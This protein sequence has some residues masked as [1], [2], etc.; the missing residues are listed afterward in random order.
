[1]TSASE[2]VWG[3]NLTEQQ[4]LIQQVELYVPEASW[5]L[6]HLQIRRGSRVV[7]LGCGPLGILDL[8]AERVG[9]EGEV[10]GVELESRFVEMAKGLMTERKLD[11]V[12]VIQGDAAATGL[13]SDF[14][15]L[16]HGRLLLI[17]VPEP[18]RVVAE[19]V[20]LVRPGG[21]I[22]VEEVDVY[23]WICEPSHPAWTRLFN[24]FETLYREDSKDPRVGRRVPRMLRAAGLDK[25]DCNVHARV[26]G[27]GDFHQEQLLLFVKLF[28]QRIIERGLLQEEELQTT[29]EDLRRHL[30]DPGTLVVSPLL[31]Q[32]WGY[33]AH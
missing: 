29:F 8:L 26:N 25:V 32:A 2:Y 24:A 6:D 11:V 20:R 27:P 5:L 9:P 3:T 1:M 23:S 17:V 28:W 15:D 18:E 10:L 13:P 21:V 30:A 33:K 16:A 12:R 22:A 19:M 31:F 14:S 7:D 4:R